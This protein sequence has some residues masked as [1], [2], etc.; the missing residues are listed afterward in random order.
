MGP[1]FTIHLAPPMELLMSDVPQ[2]QILEWLNIT[3]EENQGGPLQIAYHM[4]PD[5]KVNNC[6]IMHDELER[7][8]LIENL[9]LY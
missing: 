7:R 5:Y 4:E 2:A 6:L 3:L 9:R 8:G 1:D